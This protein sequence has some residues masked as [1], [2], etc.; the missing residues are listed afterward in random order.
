MWHTDITQA[1]VRT[2][3]NVWLRL[4]ELFLLKYRICFSKNFLESNGTQ[5]TPSSVFLGQ[6]WSLLSNMLSEAVAGL[7]AAAA[8]EHH[9]F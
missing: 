3:L 1:P 4:Q 9:C 2:S 8:A 6:D 5:M 7:Q